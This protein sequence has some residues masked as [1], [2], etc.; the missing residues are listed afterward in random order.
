MWMWQ[1]GAQLLTG[2]LRRTLDAAK[3]VLEQGG[4]RGDE[5]D[6]A[7]AQVS[8]AFLSHLLNRSASAST[9]QE[10]RLSP[11]YS[12]RQCPCTVCDQEFAG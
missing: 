3:K 12:S 8:R 4:A 9:P 10:H 6:S 7:Y 1:A 2:G 5:D 11:G